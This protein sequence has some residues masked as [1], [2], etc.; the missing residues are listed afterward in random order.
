MKT[1]YL[2]LDLFNI[3]LKVNIKIGIS[4]KRFSFNFQILQHD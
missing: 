3:K 4:Y 1:R 2:M